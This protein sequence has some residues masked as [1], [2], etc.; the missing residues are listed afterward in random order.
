MAEPVT[1]VVIFSR[2][3]QNELQKKALDFV[4]SQEGCQR[5]H[6]GPQVEDNQEGYWFV[7]WDTIECH[8]RL[9][10]SKGYGPF[11]ENIA[12]FATV[13]TLIHVEFQPSPP[14]V[15]LVQPVVQLGIATLKHEG[16]SG[17]AKLKAALQAFITA[18]RPSEEFVGSCDGVS[19]ENDTQLVW[20]A[21]W[22]KLQDYQDFL[23]AD[24]LEA[25]TEIAEV[26]IRHCT[27]ELHVP[28]SQKG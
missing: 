9:Q 3:L 18:C 27:P 22:K 11:L 6:Y 14:S 5:I 1:E 7:D 17:M 23:G 13:Q 28:S 2:V 26:E 16:G 8:H 10:E 19:K 12:E 25:I 24:E 15:I 20:I 4:R 21:G